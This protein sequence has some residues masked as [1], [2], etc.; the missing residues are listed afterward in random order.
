LLLTI[1]AE[2]LIYNKNNSNICF[3][4]SYTTNTKKIK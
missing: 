3:S 4:N 2:S 1:L